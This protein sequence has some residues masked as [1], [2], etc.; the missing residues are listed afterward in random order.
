LRSSINLQSDSRS[1]HGLEPVDPRHR[2]P[3]LSAICVSY[4]SALLWTGSAHGGS[5]P[6]PVPC[7][8]GGCPANS[9]APNSGFVQ[10][11]AASAVTSGNTLTVT[12]S[13]S[14][15]IL[16]W[17]NF[18]IAS[19]YTVNF[20]QPS[21]TAAAL[22]QIW[23]ANPTNIAGKLNANGQIYLYN[24][25]G[26]IFS[27]GAQVNVG[28][29]TA[30]T[31]GLS[32]QLFENGILSQNTPGVQPPAAFENCTGSSATCTPSPGG[33]VAVANG[34]T[35]TT[36]DG[37]R[38]ML[39]GS[40]VENQGTI[41]TPDGQTILGAGTSV[42]L[43]ASSDPSLRGLLIEVGQGGTVSNS[44]TISAPRGNITLAGLV[45]NQAGTLSATTSVSADGSI[46]LVAGDTSSSTNDRGNFNNA[47]VLGFG[48][49]LPNEGG[50]VTLAPGSVTEVL[51]DTTDT[52]TISEQNLTAGDFLPSQVN[53]VGQNVN[54]VGNATI[55]APGGAVKLSAAA[56]PFGQAG[57]SGSDTGGQIYLDSGSTIDVSGL[58]SVP[59]SA[60]QAILQVDLEGNDLADDPLLRNS[61]LHGLTVTVNANQGSPL[62]NVAPYAANIALGIDQVLTAAGSIA[63]NANGDVITRS[64]ST[65]NVFRRQR[66]LSGRHGSE[67]NQASGLDRRRL[68]HWHGARLTRLRECCEQLL[69]HGPNLGYP[70][71]LQ[72]HDVLSRLPPGRQCRLHRSPR[73]AGLPARQ[74][75]GQYRGRPLSAAV[76]S[77]AQGG[78]VPTR[79]R[80]LRPQWRFS[81]P[82]ESC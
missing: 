16:N 39:L 43:A 79:L 64:G 5:P 23:S 49:L 46:Y 1:G 9:K 19:G 12:Q 67:H 73:L 63:L 29:L 18:N 13:T 77:L 31:L 70:V 60:T 78:P 75:A 54:L 71:Q 40:A 30:T 7:V 47:Q 36:A 22:N 27:Q 11:G 6:L 35:L 65:L 33:T 51:P 59:V 44:G 42:Y 50:T 57:S 14:N 8:T 20:V 58:T 38:I 61:F 69:L 56:D 41:T 48:R 62:F 2:A 15:T 10:Y 34:A 28:S 3:T 4:A 55:R 76:G 82:P 80:E 66:R 45:V 24:Q 37:G 74:H 52:N 21:A 17:A 81:G 26:I 72:Q 68:R 32:P 53:L 25:N